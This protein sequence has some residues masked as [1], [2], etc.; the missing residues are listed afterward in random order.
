[1]PFLGI[2]HLLIMQSA[3]EP[4]SQ[5]IVRGALVLK[6]LQEMLLGNV[7]LIGTPNI[8]LFLQLEMKMQESLQTTPQVPI[9]PLT[10]SV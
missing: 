4:K 10:I 8:Y 1:M 2:W 7:S 6:A 5:A 3:K 9:G